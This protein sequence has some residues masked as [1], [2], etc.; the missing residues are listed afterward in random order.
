[1]TAHTLDARD[2]CT[3]DKAD[4]GDLVQMVKAEY[5]EMPGLCLTLSQAQRLWNLDRET[6]ATVLDRLVETRFLTRS[7][8][9]IYG[10]SVSDWRSESLARS[11]NDSA[12]TIRNRSLDGVN[13][14]RR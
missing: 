14:G 12:R 11:T 1:M 10:R 2:S 4:V 13:D 3:F 6:C 5:L 7:K 9:G 8:A